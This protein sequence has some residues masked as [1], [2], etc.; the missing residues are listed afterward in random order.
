[1]AMENSIEKKSFQLPPGLSRSPF[2]KEYKYGNCVLCSENKL[3]F[4]SNKCKKCQYRFAR[5]INLK[6][7]I[8]KFVFSKIEVTQNKKGEIFQN[9][10][11]YCMKDK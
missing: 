2:P 8:E 6:N 5:F 10:L 3:I 4:Q 7:V 11:D 1:M 9:L